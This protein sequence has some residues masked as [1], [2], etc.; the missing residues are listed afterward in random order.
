MNL[1]QPRPLS[2]ANILTESLHRRK[3]TRFALMVGLAGAAAVAPATWREGLHLHLASAEVTCEQRFGTTVLPAWCNDAGQR[4]GHHYGVAYDPF[5][6]IGPLAGGPG[7]DPQP[8]PAP[9]P[10]PSPPSPQPDPTP[11]PVPPSPGDG[12]GNPGQG[13]PPLPPGGGG[14]PND[15]D[16]DGVPDSFDGDDDNDG[17]PDWVESCWGTD[18]KVAGIGPDSDSDGFYDV[19]EAE[20]G[21]DP[22]D[23]TDRPDNLDTDGDGVADD[24]DGDG[25]PI[26]V[27]GM[28]GSND[29]LEDTDGDGLSDVEE[30]ANFLDPGD[31]D[32]DNDG[33]GDMEDHA[34]GT[35]LN[36]DANGD[37]IPDGQGNV[38]VATGT[39]VSALAT[40]AVPQG[41]A[42]LAT[43]S[44]RPA[45]SATVQLVTPKVPEVLI[46]RPSG[47]RELVSQGRLADSAL[48]TNTSTGLQAKGILSGPKLPRNSTISATGIGRVRDLK[49]LVG[50]LKAAE[51]E[52]NSMMSQGSHPRLSNGNKM[53]VHGKVISNSL[54]TMGMNEGAKRFERQDLVAIPRSFSAEGRGMKVEARHTPKENED[55][56]RIE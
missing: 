46:G 53:S 3:V 36:A 11:D 48:R 4:G 16:G 14:T 24:H 37:G 51:P 47:M 19:Q 21:T 18:S 8:S 50:Q 34:A 56:P 40:P 25:I 7:K 33:I 2:Q 29:W 55:G 54:E 43:V 52:R 17:Y 20:V 39:G 12:G 1:H 6:R 5:V 30:H 42:A 22:N 23:P 31:P 35:A 32:T 38:K 26:G 10:E 44:K 41:P 9:T 15:T 28:L 13:D 45:L 27:E 49:G